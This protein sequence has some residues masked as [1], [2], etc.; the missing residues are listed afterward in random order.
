MGIST[1]ARTLAKWG[2]SQSLSI[3]R[4]RMV[5]LMEEERQL[6]KAMGG[7]KGGWGQS[8]SHTGTMSVTL[9]FS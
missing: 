5:P 6:S 1:L 2:R 8:Q 3:T 9:T 7:V 4:P